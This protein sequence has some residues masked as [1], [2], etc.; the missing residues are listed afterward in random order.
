MMMRRGVNGG[1]GNNA[2]DTIN[3][4]ASAIAAAESRV[5]QATVQV[6]FLKDLAFFVICDFKHAYLGGSNLG[7]LLIL[8]FPLFIYFWFCFKV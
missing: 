5:P 6:I 8:G 2:L 7:V 1:D 4:A 3:A